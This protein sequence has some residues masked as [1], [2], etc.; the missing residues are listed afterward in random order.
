[1]ECVAGTLHT[2]SEHGVSSITT[3]DAHNSAASSR[4][5]WRPRR[6]KMDS[7]VSPKDEIWFLCV[8]HQISNAVY[9]LPQTWCVSGDVH[10][11][12]CNLVDNGR[13]SFCCERRTQN[14]PNHWIYRVIKKDGLNRIA[15]GS[16]TYARQLVAVFQVLC[17]LYGLK[18]TKRAL[19]SSRRLSFNELTNAKNI[20]LHRSHFALN[21]RCCTVLHQAS[22][23]VKYLKT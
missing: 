13:D 15:K 21:W 5:K 23:I 10:W 11:C 22:A 18:K 17:S 2:T 3:T 7:S 19:H 12:C 1:M 16:S 14:T 20:V 4:L 9:Q 6:F 8:C